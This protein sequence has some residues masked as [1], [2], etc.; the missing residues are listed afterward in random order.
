MSDD[1][2]TEASPRPLRVV[3]HKPDFGWIDIEALPLTDGWHVSATHLTLHFAPMLRWLEAILDG[4]DAARWLVDGESLATQFIYLDRTYS[5][6]NVAAHGVL[7][8]Q[9]GLQPPR[10]AFLKIER[11]DLVRAFYE[12]SVYMRV[13]PTIL[14]TG[15][16]TRGSRRIGT[17]NRYVRSDRERSRRLFGTM[18]RSSCR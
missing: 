13:R 4:A 5:L 9:T 7:A 3:F 18:R 12:R 16:A 1:A 15:R 6:F 8:I 17:V 2:V 11:L 14:A 10:Y